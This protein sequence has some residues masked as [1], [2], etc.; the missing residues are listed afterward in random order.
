M[1]E[2]WE[3]V[4][5]P[6]AE[7][8]WAA[9]APA[10]TFMGLRIGARM[11]VVRLG[12]GALLVHSPIALTPALRR[13]IEA[14]G[15][16]RH[17]FAPNL[18]H[19]VYAGEHQRAWPD[20][21]LHAPRGLE[22]KRKDL[23]I[24]AVHGEGAPPADWEGVLEPIAIEGSELRETVLVHAPTRTLVSCDLIEQFSSMDHAPTRLYLK[25]MGIW[26]KPGLPPI[27][28]AVYRD[29][30]AARRSIDALLERDFERVVLAHGDLVD[31]GGRDVIRRVYAWL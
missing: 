10:H 30:R 20:A 21:K 15:A 23:R 19:H 14:L 22:R 3:P 11:T 13:A 18:Y 17:V 4:L 28:R 7:G 31:A 8:L 27:L 12:G 29:R 5:E 16:V 6:I 1:S 25:A 26:Q 2:Q 24:D 9:R